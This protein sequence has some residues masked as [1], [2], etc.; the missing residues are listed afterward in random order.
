MPSGP[1]KGSASS[2]TLYSPAQGRGPGRQ[3]WAEGASEMG[4]PWGCP[5]S[6]EPVPGWARL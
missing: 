1:G 6:E 2:P 3:H 4:P 5:P